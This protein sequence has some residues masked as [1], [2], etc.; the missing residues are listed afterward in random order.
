[1]QKYMAFECPAS[2]HV[3]VAS[4]VDA[5]IAE[6][7]GLLRGLCYTPAVQQ[8]LG[9][10]HTSGCVCVYCEARAAL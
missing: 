3:Y 4:D 5:R 2:Q 8:A 9:M 6:L 10:N 1:M 7:E